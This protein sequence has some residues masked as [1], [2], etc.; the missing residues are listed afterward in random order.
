[1]AEADAQARAAR[2]ALWQQRARE[3]EEGKKARK[4]ARQDYLR[5]ERVIQRRIECLDLH[6]WFPGGDRE[7]GCR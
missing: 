3:V 7:S 6:M 2:I 4:K 5:D 1:M